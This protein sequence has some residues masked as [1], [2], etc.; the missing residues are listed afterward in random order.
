MTQNVAISVTFLA[1][2]TTLVAAVAPD[3][4]AMSYGVGSIA[5]LHR[6][7]LVNKV[8]CL[9]IILVNAIIG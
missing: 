4:G 5:S 7:L 9:Q 2:L 6:S 8:D 1:I 3:L